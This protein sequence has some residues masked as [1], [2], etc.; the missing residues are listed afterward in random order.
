MRNFDWDY[1]LHFWFIIFNITK[2]VRKTDS[3]AGG[4]WHIRTEKTSWGNARDA[5][6]R[7][8]SK[9][10]LNRGFRII[11]TYDTNDA[12]HIYC[13]WRNTPINIIHLLRL[14]YLYLLF[15]WIYKKKT[16]KLNSNHFINKYLFLVQTHTH[17][18]VCV[19][20]YLNLTKVI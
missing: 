10:L 3:Y 19:Y 14:R 6:M 16:L 5:Y 4:V 11:I 15:W 9:H 18:R 13:G 8:I 20:W 7:R 17:T 12:P 1:L 2:F